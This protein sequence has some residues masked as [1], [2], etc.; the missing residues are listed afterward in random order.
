LEASRG[1]TGPGGLVLARRRFWLH[2]F[3][4]EKVERKENAGRV[5][6]GKVSPAEPVVSIRITKSGRFRLRIII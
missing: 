3:R 2:L 6:P 4:W 5:K 1:G